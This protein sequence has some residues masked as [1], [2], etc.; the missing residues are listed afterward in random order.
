MLGNI[1][2]VYSCC[3]VGSEVFLNRE[4]NVIIK[5]SIG[6]S[7]TLEFTEVLSMSIY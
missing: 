4:Y 2:L 3:N 6:W 5:V 1:A 7:N